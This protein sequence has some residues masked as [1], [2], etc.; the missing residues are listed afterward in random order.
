MNGEVPPKPGDGELG[1]EWGES[2]GGA[3][4]LSSLAQEYSSSVGRLEEPSL[5]RAER[6][7]GSG[8]GSVWDEEGNVSMGVGGGG[9]WAGTKI[10]VLGTGPCESWVGWEVLLCNGGV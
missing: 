4:S 2:G 5:G 10:V 7:V 3:G 1:G 8:W 6:G 9:V